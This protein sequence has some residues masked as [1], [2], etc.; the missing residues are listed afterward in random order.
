MNKWGAAI[1]AVLAGLFGWIFRL[2]R[3]SAKGDQLR[4][5]AQERENTDEQVR[6]WRDDRNNNDRRDG[7]RNEIVRRG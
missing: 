6:K 7:V 5:E 4:E 2:G 3:K 1:V